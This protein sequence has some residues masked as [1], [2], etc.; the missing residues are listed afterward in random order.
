MEVSKVVEKEIKSMD[1]PPLVFYCPKCGETKLKTIV[2]TPVILD[3][4]TGQFIEVKET[5]L[6]EEGKMKCSKCNFED[7]VS[8]FLHPVKEGMWN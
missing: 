2:W 8:N 4:L 5:G 3:G 1:G 7:L 6:S